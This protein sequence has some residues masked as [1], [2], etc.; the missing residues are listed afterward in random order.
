MA[1][2]KDFVR[3][4]EFM[5]R[6]GINT[7]TELGE[8]VGVGQGAVSAWGKGTN[9]PDW[10]TSRALLRLGM[11]TEELYGETFAATARTDAE[12]LRDMLRKVMDRTIDGL[13]LEKEI[14]G[15]G[16]GATGP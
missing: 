12:R 7:Q 15:A 9:F 10:H 6:M 4:K 11:T 14:G 16:D 2:G 13:D 5:D 3:V 1:N 8:M